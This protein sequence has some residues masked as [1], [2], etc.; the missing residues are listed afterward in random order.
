MSIEHNLTPER[1]ELPSNKNRLILFG[2]PGSGKNFI[3]TLLER[4]FNYYFYDATADLTPEMRHN[5]ESGRLHTLEQRDEFAKRMIHSFALL[6]ERYAKIAFA[7]ALIM[8]RHRVMLH[9]AHP[10]ASFVYVEANENVIKSRVD[11][12]PGHILTGNYA[13]QLGSIFEPPLLP[14]WTITNNGGTDNL[15]AQLQVFFQHDTSS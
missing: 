4:E 15:L 9:E 6:K 12:R 7:Q 2:K 3:G 5:I 1:Q 8:E 10:E 14:H 11:T 13:N